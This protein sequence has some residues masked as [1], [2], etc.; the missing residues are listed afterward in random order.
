MHIS[1]MDPEWFLRYTNI[2]VGIPTRL[3]APNPNNRRDHIFTPHE[4][5]LRDLTYSGRSRLCMRN[6]IDDNQL[7]ND[8]LSAYFC[9]YR[10][11][12]GEEK[13]CA[14]GSIYWETANNAGQ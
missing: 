9:R 4:C 6:S 2:N 7:T 3:D 12:E 13:D 5:R 8:C 1:D 14:K 10:I 11:Y